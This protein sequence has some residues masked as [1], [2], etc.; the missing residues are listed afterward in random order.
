MLIRFWNSHT[1]QGSKQGLIKVIH[2][3]FK[4]RKRIKKNVE[5]YPCTLG[6]RES[7]NLPSGAPTAWELWF[8]GEFYKGNNLVCM[9]GDSLLQLGLP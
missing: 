9:L 6:S 1:V 4:K 2:I 8:G 3:Y 5:V 7:R